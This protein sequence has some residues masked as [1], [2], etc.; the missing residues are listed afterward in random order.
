MGLI[1]ENDQGKERKKIVEGFVPCRG[2]DLSFAKAKGW[3]THTKSLEFA[4]GHHE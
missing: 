1:Y 4:T 2:D 3:K